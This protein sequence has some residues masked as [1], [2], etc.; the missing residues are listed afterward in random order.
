MCLIYS[1]LQQINKTNNPLEGLKKDKKDKKRQF[2]EKEIQIALKFL[3]IY[4]TSLKRNKWKF[5]IH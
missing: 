1:E 2:K 5:K 3:R 4:S